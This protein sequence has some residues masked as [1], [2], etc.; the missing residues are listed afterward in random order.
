MFKRSIV[1]VTRKEGFGFQLWVS[2]GGNPVLTDGT[3]QSYLFGQCEKGHTK[4]NVLFVSAVNCRCVHVTTYFLRLNVGKAE[5]WFGRTCCRCYYCCTLLGG[6]PPVSVGVWV[7]LGRQS[8]SQTWRRARP[9][10]CFTY[11]VNKCTFFVFIH[12]V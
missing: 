12:Y 3:F 11:T 2:A 7:L 4:K 1:R 6:L 5:L 9:T 10:C 8:A